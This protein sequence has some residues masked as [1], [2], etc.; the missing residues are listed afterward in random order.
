M[1]GN[2]KVGLPQHILSQ[3]KTE[4]FDVNKHKNQNSCV[5][6]MEDFNKNDEIRELDCKHIFHKNC[7]DKWFTE[8]KKCPIDNH[9]IYAENN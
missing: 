6:C 1:I 7:I 5:I 8:H 3:L 9:E 2:V 4:K